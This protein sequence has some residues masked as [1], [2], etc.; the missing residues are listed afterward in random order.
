MNRIIFFIILSVYSVS[1]FSQETENPLVTKIQSIIKQQGD[2]IARCYLETQ[3]DSLEQIGESA[4]FNVLWGSLTSKMWNTNPYNELTQKYKEYLETII[5][6]EIKSDNY[7]PNRDMLPLLWQFTTDYISIL[8]EEGDKESSL[9]LLISIHRWFERYPDLKNNIQYAQS[10]LDLCTILTRDMHRYKDGETYCREYIEISKMV[11]GDQSAQYAISLYNLTTLPQIPSEEKISLLKEAI[12]IYEG[13]GTPDPSTLQKMKQGYN[14][15][16][17]TTTGITDIAE[18]NDETSLSLEDCSMLVGSGRG[19]VALNSLLQYKDKFLNEEYIDTLNYTSLI[20]LLIGT[21]LQIGDLSSAQKEIDLF[22]QS[23]GINLDRIPPEHLQIFLSSAG[24]V[25]YYLKDY[26]TALQYSQAA[27]QLFE[28]IGNYGIEYAKVLSNIAMIYAEAGNDA[29]ADFNLEAKWYI[30]EA[31]AVFE[32]RVGPPIEHGNIGISLLGNKAMV[33][34]AIGDTDGA[35]NTFKEI[36]MNFQDDINVRSAWSLAVN[37]LAILYMKMDRLSECESLLENLTSS[38]DELNYLFAQN[39]AFCR[40]YLN[41]AHKTIETVKK[42]NQYSLN[43]ISRIFTHFAEIER[44]EYWTQ[45]SKELIMINNLVAYHTGKGE[46]VSIA[47]DNALFCKNFLL[48]SSIIIDKHFMNTNETSQRSMYLQYKDMKEKLAFKTDNQNVKD[49]LSREITR[50]EKILLESIGNLGELL[51][52]ESSSWIDVKNSLREGEIAIEYCYA[53]KMDKYP[54][55]E[56]FYGAFVLRKGF[57]CPI[58]VL[59]ENVDEVNNEFTTEKTDKAFIDELYASEKTIT[60]HRML[61]EK[62]SPYLEGVH[63]VY[64]SPVGPLADINYN[65][66]HSKDGKMLNDQF[67]MV[68]LSSTANISISKTKE[69]EDYRSSVLYGNINY[70]ETMTEMAEVSS[71]YSIYTGSEIDSELST[72]SDDDRGRVSSI[73]FTKEEIDSI[74][75][76]LKKKGVIVSVLENNEANEESFKSFSGNS[77]ELLHLATHGFVF[78]SSRHSEKNTFFTSTNAYSEKDSYM[79]WAGLMLA[80]SNNVW[81]GNFNLTNVEDGILTADE[82]SRLD[83]SKTKLVVLS[84]CETAKG[85]ID[86]INGVYGLQRAFKMAGAQTIVMSLWKVQDDATAMLMIQFY[87]YLTNGEEKHQA[88]WKAMMDVKEKYHDPYY[89]AGF[90]MLD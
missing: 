5:D 41:D 46:A 49:S 39:L 83:L 2:S 79:I 37:N 82:I 22:N 17:A 89:W 65:I 72:R 43:N 76:L 47:Y 21:Y 11:F 85:K 4:T 90:I 27:C 18:V 60:L 12:S 77:P 63:T 69:D 20:T 34:N 57:E 3:K 44:D 78:G 40:L 86:P 23:I 62:L 24:L 66:L 36:V 74:S 50:Y 1:S 70:S 68:R 33:Y 26:P 42:M 51:A 32:E 30:D 53:P 88:L 67:K 16:V 87:S 80:G 48:N 71:R 25:A 55:L 14:M 52:K 8:Y 45:I 35:I 15:L 6:D 28:V 13:A 75:T 58:L 54:N 31:I 9:S 7:L 56:P 38:N 81:Q 19:D 64:Y 73:P 10:L 59:L 29:S 61:W 84:A